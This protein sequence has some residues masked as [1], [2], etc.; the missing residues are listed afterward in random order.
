MR[1]LLPTLGL[2]AFFTMSAAD[3]SAADKPA[4]RLYEMRIYYAAPGKLDALN[5]RFCDHTVKLFE[6]HGMENVG[7]FVPTGD[8]KDGKL[9]YFLSYPDKPA[10]EKSWKDFLADPEWKKAAAESEKDGKILA[11]IEYKFLTATEYSPLLKIAKTGDRVFELRTYTATKGNLGGLDDR[12]KNHT[13][14]LFE[15]HGMSNLIYWHLAASEK[16]ADKMLIYLLAHKSED[17]A[18]KS[19]DAFRM[20]PDWVAARKASEEKAGGSLTEAKGGVVSEF[21][22]PTDYSPLK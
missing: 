5:A 9:V 12:F 11:K 17:A 7:Y 13:I 20:D 2:A 22:K 3:S 21:L 15:K 4:T 1:S 19:F 10:R 16:D 14:K 6:K 8:N 18:K